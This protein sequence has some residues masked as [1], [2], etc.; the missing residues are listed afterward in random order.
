MR[1]RENKLLDEIERGALDSGAPLAATLRKCVALGGQARSAEL[2][3]WASR[4]L[5]GYGPDD[6]LPEWRKVNAPLQI[7]GVSG[8]YQVSHQTISRWTLPDFARDNLTEEVSLVQGVGELEAM[9]RDADRSV[10]RLG[11]RMGQE[12]VA[13]MNS[14]NENQFQHIEKIYWA[15]STTAIHGVLDRIRT[16]LTALVAEMRDGMPDTAGAPSPEVASQAVQFIVSGKR[17]RVVIN[18]AQ[19]SGSATSSVG[20]GQEQEPEARGW[21][22]W[23]RVSGIIALLLTGVGT[24]AGVL[25]YLAG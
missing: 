12:L 21:K 2:R 20:Q 5:N 25:Q 1:G 22:R 17:H 16:A 10:I 14:T 15:L 23:A 11:P 19:A 13:Y 4:E 24:V 9:I 18:N 8:N 6:E 7:D 3:D